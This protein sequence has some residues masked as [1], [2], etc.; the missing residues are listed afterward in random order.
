MAQIFIFTAGD[1]SARSH[2][3]DSIKSPVNFSKL[4][5]NLDKTFI[6]ELLHSVDKDNIFCWGS[7]PGK[8]NIRNWGLMKEDDYVICVYSSHYKFISR[9]TGKIHSHELAKDIWGSVNGKTWEYIYFLSRPLSIDIH[10]NKIDM[11]ESPIK[12]FGG[13]SRISDNR[14]RDIK[15]KFLSIDNFILQ[16]FNFNFQKSERRIDLDIFRK[17]INEQDFFNVKDIQD[18]RNK[19]LLSI[20]RRQGQGKFRKELLNAYEKKC[21]IT[22]SSIPE[23][24]EAAH[25]IP[26]KGSSTNH[27]QNG[28]LLR[29]DIHTL[30]DLDLLRIDENYLIHIDKSIEDIEYRK[31]D[32]KYLRLPCDEE[33]I[34]SKDAL[35]KRFENKI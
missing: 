22:N 18:S 24:L 25:I 28:I 15:D 3:N 31:F 4:E 19:I 26:Y 5:E 27:I 32:G 10:L 21:A 35:K 7:M 33:F 12:R 16:T 8:N 13:F 6:N 17:N 9:C 23:T 1:V 30:F 20:C 29:A 14:I 11:G 2:L 34:P